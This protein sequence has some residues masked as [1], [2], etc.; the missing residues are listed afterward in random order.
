MQKFAVSAIE[1]RESLLIALLDARHEGF[2]SRIRGVYGGG[3]D[4]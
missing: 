4:L 3:T 2:I 1:D